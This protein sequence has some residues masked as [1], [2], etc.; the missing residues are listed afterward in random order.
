MK[1]LS[2][3][4]LFQ[5]N[6]RTTR[7]CKGGGICGIWQRDYGLSKNSA[8]REEGEIGTSLF[9]TTPLSSSSKSV[10]TWTLLSPF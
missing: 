10:S 6:P 5:L 1:E 8:G 3:S 2:L 7:S 4:L 9:L